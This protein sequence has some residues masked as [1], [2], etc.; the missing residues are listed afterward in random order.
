MS[1]LSKFMGSMKSFEISRL[2]RFHEGKIARF[3]EQVRASTCPLNAQGLH[4]RVQGG[5]IHTQQLGGATLS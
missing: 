4:A 3:R 2:S 5:W 1:K